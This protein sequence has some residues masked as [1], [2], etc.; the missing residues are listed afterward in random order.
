M[1]VVDVAEIHALGDRRV[2]GTRAHIYL[3]V[4]GPAGVFVIDAK[5]YGGKI[6]IPS[7]DGEFT[8]SSAACRSPPG[9][10]R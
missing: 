9:S 2:P 8:W 7:V 4:I 10:A 1:A 5:R 3:F 6:H